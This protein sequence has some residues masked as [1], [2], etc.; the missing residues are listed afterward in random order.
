ME[1]HIVR[2]TEGLRPSWR[3]GDH[4]VKLIQGRVANFDFGI[5]KYDW[6]IPFK[7]VKKNGNA[8]IISEFVSIIPVF[9][10]ID[11]VRNLINDMQSS[12]AYYSDWSR[13]SN[14]TLLDGRIVVVDI[15][16]HP[17]YPGPLVRQ[18]DNP[19]FFN[20]TGDLLFAMIEDKAVN[21]S[22]FHKLHAKVVR[23]SF[24]KGI[25]IENP[26]FL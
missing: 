4:F 21:T 15:D 2:Q 13:E 18:Q 22:L 12:G 10:Q 1:Q 19:D 20:K 7:L 26:L 14:F 24:A 25:G 23:D 11:L 3:V 6:H 16:K 8:Y 5:Y 9:N 17:R